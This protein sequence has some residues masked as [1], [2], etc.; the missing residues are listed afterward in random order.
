MC[1]SVWVE[2][3]RQ[4]TPHIQPLFMHIVSVDVR[5]P[6]TCVP[7]WLFARGKVF[8]SDEEG[9]VLLLPSLPPPLTTWVDVASS[10]LW[11]SLEG[12][13]VM[14]TPGSPG[15]RRQQARINR[16]PLMDNP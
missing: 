9:G 15:R 12:A 3:R 7:P 11:W 4:D 13:F 10:W 2:T 14:Q 1:M 5:K 16:C 8:V 6:V